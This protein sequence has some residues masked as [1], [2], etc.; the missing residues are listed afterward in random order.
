MNCLSHDLHLPGLLSELSFFQMDCLSTRGF[1]F[2]FGDLHLCIYVNINFLCNKI[3]KKIICTVL[4][5]QFS[6]SVYLYRVT[7]IY[8]PYAE[9]PGFRQSAIHCHLSFLIVCSHVFLGRPALLQLSTCT[10]LHFITQ[11]TPSL[12]MAKPGAV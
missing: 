9:V 7:C 2:F 6:K 8:L 11:A 1:F 12:Y 4:I 10:C 5:F 3:C